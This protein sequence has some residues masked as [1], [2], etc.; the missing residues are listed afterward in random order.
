MARS[1]LTDLGMAALPMQDT[2]HARTATAPH[3]GHP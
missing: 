3:R 2:H 1:V